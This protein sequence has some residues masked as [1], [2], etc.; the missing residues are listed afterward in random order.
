[1]SP[2]ERSPHSRRA[3]YRLA[4]VAILVVGVAGGYL[5]PKVLHKVL[6][7]SDA[8]PRIQASAG[9]GL[10]APDSAAVSGGD[11]FVANG[12]GNSLTEVDASSG[13]HLATI[14]GPR[15]GFD[16]PTAV[17]SVGGDLFVANGAG[18]S[19]T[20]LAAGDRT[21][22][23]TIR[24]V[25]FGFADPI[26]IAPSGGRLYVLSAD[27]AVSEIDAA[28]GDLVEVA[29]GPRFA[30]NGPTSIAAG[31]HHLYVTN[32]SGDSLTVIDA[33]TLAFV[34][35]LAGPSYRFNRPT[36][37]VVLGRDLWVTNAGTDTATEVSLTSDAAVR[38]VKNSNLATPGP[39]TTGDGYVFTVSPPGD[40]PMVSQITPADGSVPWMMCNTNGPYLF[41]DPQAAVVSGSNLWVINEGSSSLTEMDAD[42]GALIRTIS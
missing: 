14:K 34:T 41:S 21:L 20:E 10:A 19:V 23:R 35:R 26:A 1:M 29:T 2:S 8:V 5:A 13:A 18:N 6:G 30:F 9:Y 31:A 16:R 4:G 17:V 7:P 39:I 28:S 42:S 36:G 15:F 24:G 40:S 22:I 27:G 11:L 3:R 12:A 33:G 32:R 38:V 37:A 25:Q